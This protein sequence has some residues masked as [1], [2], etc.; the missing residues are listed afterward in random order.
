MWTK[1]YVKDA[2]EIGKTFLY[3][4][5]R[6]ASGCFLK[7]NFILAMAMSLNALKKLN[8]RRMIKYGN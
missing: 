2:G 5:I 4:F 6:I 8:S 1:L 3:F 7:C